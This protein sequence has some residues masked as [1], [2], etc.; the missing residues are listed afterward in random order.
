[1][2][3]HT[4]NMRFVVHNVL[5]VGSFGLVCLAWDTERDAWVA[6]KRAS[7]SPSLRPEEGDRV[8]MMEAL[9]SSRLEHASELCRPC[10]CSGGGLAQAL[11]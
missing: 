7:C 5:G 10:P 9:I 2:G 8:L 4:P 1:M 6:I 11:S 3:A